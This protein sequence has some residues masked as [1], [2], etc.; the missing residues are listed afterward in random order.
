MIEKTRII[1][2]GDVIMSHY[3]FGFAT[4]LLLSSIFLYF[5]TVKIG[6]LFLSYGLGILGL[7]CF[8]KGIFIYKIA[9][10]RYN[11]Y[12]SKNMLSMKEIND[13]IKYNK[14]RLDKKAINRRRYLYTIIVS[15][16]FLFIGIVLNQKGFAIG[17]L[18]PIILYAGTE[19][20]VGLLTE[21]RLWEYQRQMEKS[22]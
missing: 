2:K 14:Y 8:G 3:Y 16:I 19:F 22:T 12:Q 18:V 10:E 6:W 11:F 9:K 15:I 7:F 21:F 4:A 20:C 13:E 1:Y 17:T 5:F